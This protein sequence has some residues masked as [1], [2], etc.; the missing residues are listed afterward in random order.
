MQKAA[1]SRKGIGHRDGVGGQ[2]ACG[3]WRGGDG[4]R[5]D[6]A[7]SPLA[8][9]GQPQVGAGPPVTDEDPE[10]VSGEPGP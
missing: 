5:P 9:H 10:A 8:R 4:S 2:S 3:S 7:T 6:S 1:G